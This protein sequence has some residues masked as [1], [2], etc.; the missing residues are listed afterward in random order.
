MAF[1]VSGFPRLLTLCAGPVIIYVDEGWGPAFLSDVEASVTDAVR[2]A[3]W[4]QTALY[5]IAFCWRDGPT[6]MVDLWSFTKNPVDDISGPLV[7]A[8]VIRA[9]KPTLE[10]GIASGNTLI[11]LGLEE[12]HRRASKNLADYL[13]SR[14]H[15]PPGIS[16]DP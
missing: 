11:V 7:E 8:Q 3:R 10:R 13:S 2:L 9:G 1:F 12:Q 6:P 16:K 14:P 5:F 15:L 4:S